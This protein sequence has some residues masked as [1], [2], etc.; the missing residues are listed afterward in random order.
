MMTNAQSVR[1]LLVLLACLLSADAFHSADVI[2]P[3]TRG[4][5]A[6]ETSTDTA[7]STTATAR[8][9]KRALVAQSS[10][11]ALG[12]ALQVTTRKLKTATQSLPFFNWNDALD[13]VLFFI[14]T[15]YWVLPS[16]LAL[17]PLYTT[18]VLG[19]GDAAMPHW[20]PVTKMDY[21]LKSP[22]AALVIGHFLASN[23]AYFLCGGYLVKKFPFV[24]PEQQE[25]SKTTTINESVGRASSV[26]AATTTAV[27]GFKDRLLTMKLIPTQQTW[28]GLLLLSAGV[29]STIFHTEQALGSY[30][31]SNSLC[32][33]DHAVAGTAT[34]Y[35]FHTCGKP[36]PRVWAL[37]VTGLAFLSIPLPG[38]AWLHSAWHYLSA[39]AA[40]LWALESHCPTMQSTA[41]VQVISLDK[42][43]ED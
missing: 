36:S 7:A 11:T 25:T 28:L 30:A 38:Y 40:T 27:V 24:K 21:I 17:V 20:W 37:G 41:M 1:G 33:L 4:Y 29:I 18:F 2:K 34:F 8:S 5:H 43:A 3:V 39:A 35:F 14:K 23:I 26:L 13:Q 15:Y 19:I 32:Y 16:F 31:L 9:S 42:E 10:Q 12:S 6:S 22:D